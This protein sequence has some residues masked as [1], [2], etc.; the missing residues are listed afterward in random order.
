MIFC[1][2]IWE[3]SIR[4]YEVPN[5]ILPSPSAIIKAL[6]KYKSILWEHTQTTLFEAM[7]GLLLAIVFAIFLAIIMNR[8]RLIKQMIYPILV[9]S[10][11]IPI[12]ALAPIFMVWLGFGVLPKILIVILVCFFPISISVA[13]GLA[14]VDKD[15]IN[16]LKS[17]K[18]TP[19]QIFV[20]VELPATLP[21]FLSGLK[22]AVT[23]SIMGAVI[24]EWIGARN[25]LGIFLTRAMK[26]HHTDA[27]F[28]DILIIVVMSVG[29]F[30]LVDFL[31]K[32]IMPWN[33]TT[34]EEN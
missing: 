2:S 5:Y 8:Y 30:Q 4:I 1:I 17:M 24:G 14:T 33:K 29:L 22:I 25:G 19:W 26:S 18:A 34:K 15:L 28:A 16:L 21:S 13:E 27:M 9:V 32:K 7:I 11:T 20:K 6:D 3:F 10:Q 23:Y 12:I 31:G